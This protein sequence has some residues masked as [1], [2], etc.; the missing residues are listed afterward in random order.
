MAKIARVG[1]GS[2][3]Q[4]VG[5]NPEGYTY[6]VNDNVR[7]G[8]RIQVISTS[9]K[10]NKF[11]TT[12]VPLSTH[13]ENT[14]KGRQATVDALASGDK[15]VE[16]MLKSQ[17]APN[18]LDKMAKQSVTRSY[19]GAELGVGRKGMTQQQFLKT[20]RGGNLRQYENKVGSFNMTAS[21]AEAQDSFDS[22]SAKFMKGEE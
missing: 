22:Y 9:R 2:K 12:A 7:V 20:V 13:G 3:G 11:G 1:Y 15:E 16:G 19:T 8:D 17:V 21:A 18:E 14:V 5:D 10:G 6:L 4:G